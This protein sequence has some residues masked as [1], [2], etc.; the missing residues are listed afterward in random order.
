M[1][2]KRIVF[3][4][5]P[6]FASN[7]L[8][9][10]LNEKYNVVLVVTQPDK[11]FG[12]KKILTPSACKEVAIKNNIDVFTPNSLKEEYSKILEYKPDLIITCAYGQFLPKELLDYPTYKSINI[13]GSLLPLY[14]GGAPIQRSI[15]NGDAKTGITIMYM[16]E[17]MDEGDMLYQ[18]EMAIDIKDTNTSLFDKLSKLGKEMILEFLPKFFNRDF[19]AIK[20]DHA[21][22][23]IA[24]NIK[25]EEEFINFND[26]VLK[27]YNHIRGL[28]DNPGC[29][30]VVDN[31]KYKIHECFYKEDSNSK[32]GYIYGLE[33]KYFKI[34]AINGY[35]QIIKIQKES[36]NMCNAKEFNNGL[37]KQLVGKTC[38]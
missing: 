34:G 10:L 13:H 2:D 16:N 26:D 8:E 23:T 20:Q 9:G 38:K 12:R 27:V 28:L 30:F 3:M 36:K 17:K 18:K 25:K 14:R 24:R 4:G 1:N 37:G 11:P 33:D 32:P 22:A 7:I 6:S 15:M 31:D 35:I 21:L 29:Y 5:T 19:K